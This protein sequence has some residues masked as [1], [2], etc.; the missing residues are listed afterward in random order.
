[1]KLIDTVPLGDKADPSAVAITP[2]GKRALVTKFAA[3]KVALLAIDGQKVSYGKY[4]MATGLWPYN[5]Q[6]TPDGKLGIVNNNGNS[7]A[8][9]GQIDTAAIIDLEL[10]PPRVI[11]QVAVGDGPEG[12]AVSPVGGYA[13]SLI[14]NGVANT[15]TDF[16]HHDRSYISLLRIE[17]KKVH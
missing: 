9:D 14:L 1:V 15:K 12:L 17:G 10:D 16:F 5:V 7:G 11:D 8:S 13:A 3:H 4:D 6:I 2:D